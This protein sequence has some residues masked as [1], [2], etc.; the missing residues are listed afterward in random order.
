[1]ENS[2]SIEINSPIS[3]AKLVEGL[4][5]IGTVLCSVGVY[6]KHK[7]TASAFEGLAASLHSLRILRDS[8]ET[9]N[10]MNDLRDITSAEYAADLILEELNSESN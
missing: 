8:F 9:L 6:M 2:N 1:M 7:E 5:L 3:A 4:D 10:D